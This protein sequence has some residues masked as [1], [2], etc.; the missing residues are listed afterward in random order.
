MTY[1]HRLRARHTQPVITIVILGDDRRRWRP[2][3]HK[4]GK[5]GSWD[6]CEWIPIK[7]LDLGK[8]MADLESD[9]N[10]FA[11]FVAAHLETMATRKNLL[12]NLQARKLDSVDGLRW[13]Q[14]IDWLMKLPAEMNRS[15]VRTVFQQQTEESMKYVSFAEQMGIEKGIEKGEL[16]GRI[17]QC[18]E[19]LKQEQTPKDNLLAMPL[20]ELEAL[21]ARLRKQLLPNGD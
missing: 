13:Y 5:Y 11:L 12:N 10:V 17:R 21:L 14:L 6:I 19:L 20:D 18:Q 7:L 2:K 4:E 16:L 8:D 3:R 15:V 1:R 9:E